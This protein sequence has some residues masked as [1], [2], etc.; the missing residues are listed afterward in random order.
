MEGEGRG[1]VHRQ[2]LGRVGEWRKEKLW[3]WCKNA[4]TSK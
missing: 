4:Q 2:G 1:E 3:S